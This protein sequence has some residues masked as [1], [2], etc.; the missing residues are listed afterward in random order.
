MG[1]IISD[2]HNT[3]D[4]L[5][6]NK[7]RSAKAIRVVWDCIDVN[8]FKPGIVSV[9]IIRKYNLPDPETCFN[10]LTLG[11]LSLPDALYKGYDRLLKVFFALAP[12]YK[13]LRLIIAGRG[14]YVE[15]L[16][17]RVKKKA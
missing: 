8:K 4:W 14:N 2:C 13:Q 15:T 1:L 3:A 7:G 17:E 11:R 6:K 12:E 5:T 16:K 10:I 9:N